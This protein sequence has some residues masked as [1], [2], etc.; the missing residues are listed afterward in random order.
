MQH[1]LL[2][3]ELLTDPPLTNP[4]SP[5]KERG[6]TLQECILPRLIV[7]YTS[8]ELVWE[9]NTQHFCECGHV[10]GL[11]VN[12]EM[13]MV[14]TEVARGGGNTSTKKLSVDGWMQLVGGYSKRN[15]TLSSDKLIAISG[16]AQMVQATVSGTMDSA[17]HAGI[18]R[19]SL[20]HHL[21]WSVN[22]KPGYSTGTVLDALRG[23]P[24]VPLLPGRGLHS[25]V[26]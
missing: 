17:Y 1:S 13:P 19:Q 3:V 6:W 8:S 5:L 25:T 11:T 20:P 2:E 23:L 15:L 14:K 10:E 7:H 22:G 26:L 4:L 9:C 18:F 12:G 16:L 21:L 24:L